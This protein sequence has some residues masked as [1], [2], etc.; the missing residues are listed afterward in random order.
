M[1]SERQRDCATTASHWTAR[2]IVGLYIA[3]LALIA[4]APVSQTRLTYQV[5]ACLALALLMH[6]LTCYQ[7]VHYLYDHAPVT[8]RLG[9]FSVTIPYDPHIWT[10]RYNFDPPRPTERPSFSESPEETHPSG[11]E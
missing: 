8:K 5:F 6:W 7:L 3:I 11:K 2:I 4:L 9:W 10:F 1:I